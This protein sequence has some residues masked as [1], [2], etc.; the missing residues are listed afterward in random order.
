MEDH[1]LDQRTGAAAALSTAPGD[2]G[3]EGAAGAKAASRKLARQLGTPEGARTMR[4]QQRAGRLR[5][6]EPALHLPPEP[7]AGAGDESREKSSPRQAPH[8]PAD[9]R[10]TD[11]AARPPRPISIWQPRGAGAD[12]VF[13]RP[14]P[15]PLGDHCAARREILPKR[16]PLPLRV[17]LFGE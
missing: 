10:R 11:R 7:S 13:V 5:L 17:C 4:A 9:P 15:L 12:L 1:P 14:E 6:P 2:L 8:A 3:D 16:A